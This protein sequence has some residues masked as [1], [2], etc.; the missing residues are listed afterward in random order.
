MY[1][2]YFVEA[3][4]DIIIVILD[5][6][7]ILFLLG[8]SLSV[9]EIKCKDKKIKKI[10]Y[11]GLILQ[12]FVAV[13]DHFFC[14]VPTIQID[15]RMFER[16]AWYSYIYN[17]DLGRGTYS[18]WILNPIYKVLRVR[19]AM[20]FSVLNI[21]FTLLTNLNIYEIFK[22]LKL[23]FSLIRILMGILILS[24]IS[25]I[26]KTGI[27]RE[28]I[29]I[30]LISYSLKNFIDYFFRKDSMKI[31]KSFIS[32]GIAALFHGGVIFLVSGYIILLIAKKSSSKLN[33]YC[34][35]IAMVV[36]FIIFKDILLEK[37]GGGDVEAILSANNREVLKNAGSGYLK[38]VSTT[39][40][41]QIIIYLPL[42]I[43]YFL[44]S[45]TLDMIRGVLDIA[46]FTLN[47]SIFIYFTIYG[48]IIY[49]KIKRKL[50]YREK[51]IIKSLVISLISTIIVFSIGTRNAGTAMRHRDK[52]VPFLVVCFGI[53]KNREILE[54]KNEERKTN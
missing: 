15:P 3:G 22:K 43:F 50:N 53:V 14:A 29:I 16:F 34:L 7:F 28:A 51:E 17:I 19:A 44:Y 33:Q 41:G 9:I 40:L 2:P 48:A 54:K 27:Q 12:I 25:L 8:V 4:K 1:L 23:N 32:I 46:T 30:L 13:V 18:Y 31:M 49:K 24:P 10:L 52:I 35:F 20:I 36:L 11:I 38:N 26:M 37:V 6:I 5:I 21:F 47:S 42:F 39:S 45:P